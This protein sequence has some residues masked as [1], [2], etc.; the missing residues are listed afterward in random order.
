MKEH[1]NN[2]GKTAL[3]GIY[4]PPLGG[5]GAGGRAYQREYKQ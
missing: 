3:E 5:G 1:K 2:R 4:P